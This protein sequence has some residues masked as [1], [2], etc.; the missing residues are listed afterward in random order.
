MFCPKCGNN[1]SGLEEFCP[2]CGQD[3]KQARSYNVSISLTKEQSKIPF[4]RQKK[5]LVFGLILLFVIIG[6]VCIFLFFLQKR[7]I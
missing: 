5:F 7:K 1:L 6:S 4:W 3:L 2:K